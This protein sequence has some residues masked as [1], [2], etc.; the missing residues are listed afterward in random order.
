MIIDTAKIEHAILHQGTAQWTA[1]RFGLSPALVNQY[2][3]NPDAKAYRDWHRM[4]LETAEIIM[5]TILEEEKTMENKK[6]FEEDV[7][8][9]GKS[10][11]YDDAVSEIY[12]N[13]PEELEIGDT[14]PFL[15]S[16]AQANGNSVEFEFEVVRLDEDGL[17]EFEYTGFNSIL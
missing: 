1:S 5:N 8:K 16:G 14:Q 15:L 2:R 10:V 7:E 6:R 4:S 13:L 17:P 11:A 12:A 9:Y 3:A